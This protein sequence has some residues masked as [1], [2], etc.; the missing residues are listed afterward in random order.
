M[1]LF[2][3]LFLR[4]TSDFCAAEVGVVEFLNCGIDLDGLLAIGISGGNDV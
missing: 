2:Q 1:D 3:L 4:S